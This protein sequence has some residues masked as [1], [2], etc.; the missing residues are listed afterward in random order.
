MTK[1]LSAMA[2]AMGLFAMAGCNEQPGGS[3]GAADGETTGTATA[4]S[5]KFVIGMSQCNLGEP[6]RVQ[7]NA[8]IKKATEAHP[9]LSVEFKSIRRAP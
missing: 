2:L 8:D 4:D 7:M 9:E 3:G 1:V 5:G 6:W